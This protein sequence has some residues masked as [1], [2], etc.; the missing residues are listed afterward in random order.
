MLGKLS[1]GLQGAFSLE[2]VEDLKRQ[3]DELEG[4]RGDGE[5]GAPKQ[6]P[7]NGGTK[8]ASG[9]TTALW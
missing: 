2:G 1:G 9:S 4:S 7:P 6:P 8:K 5:D 3:Q